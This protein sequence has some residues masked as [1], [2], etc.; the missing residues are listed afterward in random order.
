M[1]MDPE[2]IHC[3]VPT[4]PEGTQYLLRMDQ[5]VLATLWQLCAFLDVANTIWRI[6]AA[7]IL[8]HPMAN[9][10]EGPSDTLLK[11]CQKAANNL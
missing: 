4:A 6:C 1:Q 9:S 5:R 11:I 7:N 10:P 3:R 2:I 8:R